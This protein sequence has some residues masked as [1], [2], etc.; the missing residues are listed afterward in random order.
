[1]KAVAVIHANSDF[2]TLRKTAGKRGER[3]AHR[4]KAQS[5]EER[6]FAPS[7]TPLS[8]IDINQ[9]IR[10]GHTEVEY[11]QKQVTW[12]RPSLSSP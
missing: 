3:T 12:C 2:S 7:T 10:E 5:A 6:A 8:H 9:W 4:L 1:M 11:V